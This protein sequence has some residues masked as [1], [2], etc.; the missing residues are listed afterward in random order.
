MSKRMRGCILPGQFRH[1]GCAALDQ[2]VDAETGI[3][4]AVAAEEHRF[5]VRPPRRLFHQHP[6]GVLPQWAL[7]DLSAL[8]VEGGDGG[9]AVSLAERDVADPE[10]GGL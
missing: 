4:P 9:A 8:S 3:G 6:S 5:A 1:C 7:P 10:S 2:T